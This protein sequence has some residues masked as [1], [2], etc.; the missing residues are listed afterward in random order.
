MTE[1]LGTEKWGQEG[2]FGWRTGQGTGVLQYFTAGLALRVGRGSGGSILV[3]LL[4]F[5]VLDFF[6]N[7]PCVVSEGR[8]VG[9]VE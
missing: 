3:K 8:P 5:S 1:T 4:L 6:V 7:D 9:A 2:G